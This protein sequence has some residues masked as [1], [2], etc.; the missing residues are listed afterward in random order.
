MNCDA[1]QVKKDEWG[2]D[3]YLLKRHVTFK[4]VQFLVQQLF[5][6][7]AAYLRQFQGESECF[8][9]FTLG[10]KKRYL[11]HDLQKIQNTVIGYSKYAQTNLRFYKRGLKESVHS[12]KARAAI[13]F[14]HQCMEGY[15]LDFRRGPRFIFPTPV[16]VQNVNPPFV[17]LH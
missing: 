13:S 15:R 9:S 7:I 1:M 6:I 17:F 16:A 10:H 3:S 5:L 12:F 11:A 14:F 2:L 4:P 8:T